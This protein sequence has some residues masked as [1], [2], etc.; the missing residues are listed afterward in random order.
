[1]K[2]RELEPSDVTEEYWERIASALKKDYFGQT[3]DGVILALNK[4]LLRLWHLEGTDVDVLVVWSVQIWP[5]GRELFLWLV[6][7][8]GWIKKFDEILSLLEA[9]AFAENCTMIGGYARGMLSPKFYKRFGGKAIRC[10]FVK[11][12]GNGRQRTDDHSDKFSV[13]T[14]H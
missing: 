2:L 8:K 1:V 7:G 6:A 14:I 3:L 10:H 11:E 5:R 13:A 4:G 9:L 12:L